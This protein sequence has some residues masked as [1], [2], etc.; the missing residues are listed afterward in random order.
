M[1]THG[2]RP[3]YD[4]APCLRGMSSHLTTRAPVCRVDLT[5]GERAQHTAKRAEVVKAKAELGA[6]L[7][8]ISQLEG[9]P[10][11]FFQL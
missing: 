3:L 9:L 11:W 10:V 8:P 4:Y 7:A 6:K 5:E 2:R 1:F